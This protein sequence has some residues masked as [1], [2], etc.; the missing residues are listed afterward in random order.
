MLAVWWLLSIHLESVVVVAMSSFACVFFIILIKF[1]LS[2]VYFLFI[3]SLFS[4]GI[5]IYFFAFVLFS[6]SFIKFI[7]FYCYYYFFLS[8]LLALQNTHHIICLFGKFFF[9]DA[10]SISDRNSK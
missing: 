9:Y 7:F 10:L 3:I 8:F 5:Y 2:L 4:L 1:H 6:F